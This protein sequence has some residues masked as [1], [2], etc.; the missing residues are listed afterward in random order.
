MRQFE[1]WITGFRVEKPI[2]AKNAVPIGAC[3]R[4]VGHRMPSPD[5]NVIIELQCHAPKGDNDP[6]P[7][8]HVKTAAG[9]WHDLELD[10]GAHEVLWSPDPKA[11]LVN[12]GTNAY[13]GFFVSELRGSCG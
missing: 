7:Y 5:G 10:E 12:G 4:D 3:Y 6:V 1:F 2:W 9:N 11:F 8:L 13:A